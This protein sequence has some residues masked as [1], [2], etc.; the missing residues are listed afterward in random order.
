[1]DRPLRSRQAVEREARLYFGPIV[2]SPGIGEY[3]TGEAMMEQAASL[4]ENRVTYASGSN[5]SS[6]AAEARNQTKRVTKQTPLEP[7]GSTAATG[8]FIRC[9]GR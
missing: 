8:F 6:G 7:G 3:I 9:E 4:S 2:S 5:R 1:M